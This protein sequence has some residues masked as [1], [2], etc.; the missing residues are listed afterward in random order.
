VRPTP[1][2]GDSAAAWDVVCPTRPS[3]LAGVAVAGFRGRG[4][5]AA[6]HRAFPHPAVTLAVEFGAGPLIVD[7][8]DGRQRCGSL[9][10]GPGFGPRAVWVRDGT[11]EAVQVRLSPL[12]AH[13]VLG[14][15]ASDL[16][17][18]VVPLED[19]WGR[20]ASRIREQ[21]SGAASWTERFAAIDALLIHRYQAA[22]SG[23]PSPIDPEIAWAWSRILRS[24][25]QVRVDGLASDI[26]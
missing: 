9:V 13:A 11:F 26:G 16:N 10:A 2:E 23:S 17:G 12:V 6:G 3:R 21:L 4:G 20:A 25:G 19:V 5:T 18:A 22:S 15:P 14:L 8:A 24:G 7:D 1:G